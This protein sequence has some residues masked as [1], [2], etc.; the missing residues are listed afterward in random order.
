MNI[1]NRVKILNYLVNDLN[2]NKISPFNDITLSVNTSGETKKNLIGMPKNH[3]NEMDYTKKCFFARTGLINNITVIDI[4]DINIEHNKEIIEILE[5]VCNLITESPKSKGRH[6]WFKYSDKFKNVASKENK[7]DIRNDGGIIIC[8]PTIYLDLNGNDLIYKFIKTPKDNQE[9]ELQDIPHELEIYLKT[10]F[11]NF[12]IKVDENISLNHNNFDNNVEINNDE[13]N[14]LLKILDNLN[15]SR[16]KNYSDWFI[17]GAICYNDANLT[18]KDFFEYSQRIDEYQFDYEGQEKAW[19]SY[20]LD[21]DK[22]VSSATLWKWL[23]EDNISFYNKI[24]TNCNYVWNFIYNFNNSDCAK[25]FYNIYAN[26]YIFS[27]KLGWFSIN[28]YNVWLSHEKN[29]PDNIILKINDLFKELINSYKIAE[30]IRN[31][32]KINNAL[33]FEDRAKLIKESKIRNTVI[34]NA[35]K[36]AGSYKFANDIFKLLKD[37]YRNNNFDDLVDSN[38]HLFA[39]NDKL[40]DMEKGIIRNINPDDY[41]STTIG[42]NYPVKSNSNIREDIRKTIYNMFED[43]EMTE[44]IFYI[45]STALFG[46]NKFQK[47]YI[48][49]GKG[50]NGKGLLTSLIKS[51]F[52]NFYIS[53]SNTIFTQKNNGKDSPINQLVDAKQKRLMMTTEPEANDSL[54][55]SDIKKIT[56]SDDI[57]ARYCNEKNVHSYIPKFLLFLQCNDIPKVNSLD[58]GFKRRLIIINF[59]FQFR[60]NPDANNQFERQANSDIFLKFSSN[61]NYRDEFILLLIEYALKINNYNDDEFDKLTPNAIINKNNEF[62]QDNNTIYEWLSNNYIRTNDINDRVGV[63]EIYTH[64]HNDMKNI[65]PNIKIIGERKFKQMMLFN[66]FEFK[67]FNSGTKFIYIKKLEINSY[68]ESDI[69]DNI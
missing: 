10:K 54:Q 20:S 40:I 19:N 42:Y 22:K 47:F 55:I 13:R 43:N 38:K 58:N 30:Q 64:Y 16:F 31:N 27:N 69:L 68:D 52:N 7:L 12:Y 15:P 4:D 18:K 35:Y 48:F 24:I 5:P 39:F 25:Y 44:Y 9:Y 36:L 57:Q 32:Q 46:F 1:N 37:Y 59:P 29:I 53:V 6:Y 17:F 65:S 33:H 8:P 50:G 34:T 49:T 3:E 21:K 51:V 26:D 23:K 14:I 2:I 62:I 67:I 56:G 66:K 11:N 63:R 41:I 28:E 61:K 60:P 45:L